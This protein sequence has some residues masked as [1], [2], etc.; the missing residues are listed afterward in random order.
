MV[1]YK[2]VFVLID[3]RVYDVSLLL[4]GSNQRSSGVVVYITADK[5][6]I[7]LLPSILVLA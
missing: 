2:I 7:Y 4:I 6:P 1:L 3:K 5:Q